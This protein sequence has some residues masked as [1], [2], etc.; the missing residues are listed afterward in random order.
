M[1][2][3]PKSCSCKACRAGKRT[4]AQKDRMRATERAFRRACKVSLARGLEVMAPTPH[5]DRTD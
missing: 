1:K 3:A 5:G 4:K 2:A